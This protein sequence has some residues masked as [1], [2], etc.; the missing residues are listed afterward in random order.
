MGV[1]AI[2]CSKTGLSVLT[3]VNTEYKSLVNGWNETLRVVCPHCGE[4]HQVKVMDAYIADAISDDTLRGLTDG[5][6]QDLA[7]RLTGV[8]PRKIKPLAPPG[9]NIEAA[10]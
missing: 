4:S 6:V 3:S 10:E 5:Q 9:T 2:R 1:I 7:E 8:E